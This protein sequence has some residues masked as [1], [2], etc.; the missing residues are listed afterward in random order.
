MGNTQGVYWKTTTSTSFLKIGAYPSI[1]P[2]IIVNLK[3][4]PKTALIVYQNP[5]FTGES[6][7]FTNTSN[8]FI[9]I[10]NPVMR[11]PR[12]ARVISQ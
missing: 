5:D 8:K 11:Q 3:L 7:S 4:A 12:S 6:Y 10:V 2:S 1:P 9:T